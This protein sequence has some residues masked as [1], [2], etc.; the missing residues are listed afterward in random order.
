[1]R[2]EE[3]SSVAYRDQSAT[4]A[5][6]QVKR[7]V[8]DVTASLSDA[9]LEQLRDENEDETV[10]VSGTMAE[11]AADVIDSGKAIQRVR[12]LDSVD[13]ALGHVDGEPNVDNTSRVRR[14]IIH[15][16]DV[17]V[18]GNSNGETT[19]I[20]GE[21]F[22]PTST[23]SQRNTSSAAAQNGEHFDVAVAINDA[24]RTTR[25]SIEL[26]VDDDEDVSRVT[27]SCFRVLNGVAH[28]E[29]DNCD[30]DVQKADRTR[31]T[32][33]NGSSA[34]VDVNDSISDDDLSDDDRRDRKHLTSVVNDNYG[35]VNGPYANGNSL[36]DSGFC[37]GTNWSNP[38]QAADLDTE[39]RRSDATFLTAESE[40]ELNGNND[41]EVRETVEYNYGIPDWERSDIQA[42]EEQYPG[43]VDRTTMSDY[44]D[45]PEISDV[46]FDVLAESDNDRLVLD[47]QHR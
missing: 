35:D 11:I 40:T 23:T 2:V 32:N 30:D 13:S 45:Q 12:P 37:S 44:H 34:T 46:V 4:S 25:N 20:G 15:S 27:P 16:D 38:T 28:A 43:H 14:E 26:G 9:L 19:E 5:V 22:R 21:Y 42:F 8:D 18:N 29:M 1:M 41:V 3:S 17:L 31:F 33:G 47:A 7:Q 24:M 6:C 39:P 10:L 36:Y